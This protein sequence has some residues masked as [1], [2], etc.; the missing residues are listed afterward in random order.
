MALNSLQKVRSYSIV[1]QFVKCA[2][3]NVAAQSIMQ[4]EWG[5]VEATLAT[6]DGRKLTMICLKE[7]LPL[8][9]AVERDAPESTILSLLRA[10]P[11]AAARRGRLGSTPLHLAAQQK[12]SPSIVVA[13]IR[14]CPEVLDQHNDSG[15]LACDYAQRNELCREALL[16]PTACWIEDIDK[17]EYYEKIQKRKEQLRQKVQLLRDGLSSSRQRR[18]TLNQYIQQLELKLRTQREVVSELDGLEKQLSGMYSSSQES[19]DKMRGRIKVLSDEVA[20]EPDDEETMMR[21]L[22]KRTY[23]E[24]VQRQYEKLLARTDQIRKEVHNVRALAPGHRVSVPN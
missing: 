9:M 13:L 17:E 7:D 16:R 23:M 11:E 10:Y 18:E 24:G 1:L 21:S 6:E 4:M 2:F 20:K 5:G 19:I 22:M 8:H 14:A 15:R 3:L 12:L